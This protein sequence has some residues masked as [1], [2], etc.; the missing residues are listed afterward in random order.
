MSRPTQ[1][2]DAALDEWL[3]EPLCQEVNLPPQLAHALEDGLAA[4]R[5]A[6]DIPGSLVTEIIQLARVVAMAH[7]LVGFWPTH[8]AHRALAANER[9]ADTERE[10]QDLF[11]QLDKAEGI[12]AFREAV[13]QF[14]LDRVR[15]SRQAELQV[16]LEAIRPEFERLEAGHSKRRAADILGARRG[17]NPDTIRKRLK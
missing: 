9:L 15:E 4:A 14:G 16:K 6:R 8:F 10:A 5:Q 2:Y 1:P 3:T 17:L 7:E 12:T 11:F 13:R